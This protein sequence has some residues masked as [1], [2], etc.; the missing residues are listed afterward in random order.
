MDSNLIITLS[1]L[2]ISIV[3]FL[4][5]R[6]SVDLVALLVLVALGLSRVLTP[7]EVF[8]GLSDPAVVTILAVFVLAHGLELTGIAER[9]GAFLA[10][11]RG[12]EIRLTFKLMFLAA[13]MSL[14]MNNIAVAAIL[15]PA[16]S[17]IAK[18]AKVS[19]SRLLMPLAFAALLGGMATLFATTNIVANSILRD[20]GY[21]VFSLIDF[22]AI[23]IPLALVGIFYMS[24][25]GRRMLPTSP[26]AER[27]EILLGTGKD[28]LLMYQLG[29]RLFRARIPEGSYLVDRKLVESTLRDKYGLNLIAVER[30]DQTILGPAPD[31]AFRK[32]DVMLL[33]GRLEEFR[34][35]DVEPYLEILPMREYGEKDLQSTSSVIVEV[36]LAPRSQ[37]V[38][39]TLKETHF[40]ETYGM[41]ILAVWN[42]ERVFRTSLADHRLA[43]GDALLLQGPRDRL[44][45]L[46][47]NPD[48]IVLS[49]EEKPLAEISS[50]SR[51]ALSV[52]GIS[53]GL[54]ALGIFSVSE[55]MLA[56][57]L[58]LVLLNVL[59]MEQAYRAVDWRVIFL[60]AGMLPLGLAMT[61]T[62]ATILIGDALANL[63]SPFGS[64]GL[65]FG[66][67]LLTVVLSQAMK[68][69][70]VSAVVAPIAIQAALRLGA[71]PRAMVMG[72]ALATSMA[73]VTPL[74]HPVNILMLGPGGYRFK[75]FFRV[76]FPLTLI[77]FALVMVL[78]PRFWPLAGS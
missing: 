52:L 45:I 72:V 8:S 70:A 61:K 73:F 37:L 66:L 57:A 60:V 14:F 35:R 12:G 62:G 34:E 43:F 27:E 69:A 59:T 9:M 7:Q 24:L 22:A 41:T 18:R 25:I 33:A 23:G 13:F 64:Y 65:L 58:L 75:D 32:G 1:I 20:S 77:L 67:L 31:F 15:M 54:A 49:A 50:K 2:A 40:R 30:D 10:R 36:V 5:E 63:A 68:G 55:I 78:L 21:L 29:E 38:G 42:G 76:G 47:S 6:L 16:M 3:L 11:S 51:I 39:R 53:V 71:D 4:S 48:F 46:R 17:N 74:G 44:P 28:L 19:I 26:S 56:G